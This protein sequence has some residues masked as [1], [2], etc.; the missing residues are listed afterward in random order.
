MESA[1]HISR[2]NKRQHIGVVTVRVKPKTFAHVAIDV[3]LKGHGRA[4]LSVSSLSPGMQGFS[5]FHTRLEYYQ[6]CNGYL[7]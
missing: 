3:N 1:G 6:I 4:S 2:T 7:K 5:L